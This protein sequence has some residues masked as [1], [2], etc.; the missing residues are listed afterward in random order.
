LSNLEQFKLLAN[1]IEGSA[2]RW[3]KYC[4]IEAPE[5]EKLPQEWKNKTAL[6]RLCILRALR[7]DRMVYAVRDFVLQKMGKR[8]VDASRIPLPK[9]F[10]EAGPATPIFFVLSPGVDPVKEVCMCHQIMIVF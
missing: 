9:S 6:E 3:Q 4:E 7:P 2:K 5:N 1:D 10:E 8:Y